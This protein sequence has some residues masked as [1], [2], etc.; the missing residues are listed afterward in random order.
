[1]DVDV[2]LLGLY[3]YKRKMNME[4]TVVLCHVLESKVSPT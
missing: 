4:I 3:S 2:C 1:M